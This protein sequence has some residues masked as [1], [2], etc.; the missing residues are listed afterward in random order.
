[1]TMFSHVD[2]PTASIFKS[3]TSLARDDHLFPSLILFEL[4]PKDLGTSSP[5]SKVTP[6]FEGS[7]TECPVSLEYSTSF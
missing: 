6:G 5:S 7:V 4:N 3:I 2:H 1:M